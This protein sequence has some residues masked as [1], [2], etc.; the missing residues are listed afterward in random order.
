[1]A[2]VVA[3]PWRVFLGSPVCISPVSCLYLTVSLVS[4]CIPVS[5]HF[6]ADPLY[7]CIP[8]YPT[9][10]SSCI[11]RNTYLA[12]SSCIPLYLTVSHRLENEI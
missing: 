3:L 12:V 1:M 8:L 11:I 10:L 9:V 5:S 4:S 2:H 6:G 7:H